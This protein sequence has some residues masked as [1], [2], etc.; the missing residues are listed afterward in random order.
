MNR[1]MWRL[2]ASCAV[3]CGALFA[4]HAWAAL[5]IEVVSSMPELVSN[6]DALI[7]VTGAS[8]APSVSY[9]GLDVSNRFTPDP[10]TPGRWLGLI[11]GFQD[12]KETIE[13]RF[14]GE[15]AA[16]N[17]VNH[18]VNKTLFAGPQQT[19]FLCELDALGLKPAPTANL[20]PTRNPDCAA[21]STVKYYYRNTAGMWQEWNVANR[22]TDVAMTTT[23]E[24]KTVPL[25]VRQERGV[26]NRAGYIINI[27][28]DPA[29]GPA[30]TFNSRGGSAWNGKLIYSFGPGARAGY[31]QG[32]NFGGLNGADMFITETQ[33]GTLDAYI[34]RGY[35]IASGSLNSFGTST[36]DVVSAETAYKV[37]ERFIE[38]F[39][40]PTF[41][42]GHGVSGGS[43]QQ[44]MISNAYPGILD[45]IMPYMLFADAMTF[46]Q[47]MF[48]CE[49]LAN[50][51]KQGDWSREQLEAVG[52][53]YWGYCV[54]NGARYPAQR[55]DNCDT[56][57]LE[58]VDKDPALK[59]RGVRCTYQDNM[60]HTFGVDPKTG[61]ARSPWDNVGIQYGL[62][63]LNDGVIT[64][65][66]FLDINSRIG[67]HDADGNI[68]AERQVGDPEALRIAYETG[69]VNLGTGGNKNVPYVDFRRY[70][71][72][73]PFNRGDAN[74]D[75]HNSVHSA[76]V[77]A[78][79]Q[80]YTGTNA[81]HVQIIT[82][83]GPGRT[84]TTTPGSPANVAALDALTQMDKW[85]T[86]I[87]AD[88]SSKSMAEKVA[89]NRPADFV[90]ACY[91]NAGAAVIQG[92][93]TKDGYKVE[94]V[95][96]WDKCNQIFP[97]QTDPRIAAGGPMTDDVFK[98]QLKPIDMA[99]YKTA[100]NADQL[101]QLKTVF[102]DGVC[103]YSKPG[104]GNTGKI[105]TW[106]MFTDA[107][108]Y[109]GL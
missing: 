15:K 54:S 106:A 7:A 66:Q 48:D 5:G 16:V 77:E 87:K 55:A 38:E 84:D 56:P 100:P 101:A 13:A 64:W 24:G 102:A 3:A 99:D 4:S 27:L 98:C 34:T 71:D 1:K 40:T 76:I 44:Q 85:L 61:Y 74:V 91:T 25:I 95:T 45:G 8:G 51:F 12:G 90:N 94:K 69:R 17:I 11:V 107:G 50:V 53:L 70:L 68:V 72:G 108:E 103:D 43:M 73:D 93:P 105:V 88:T 18:A 23:S 58:M 89:A 52:G 79:L 22:P 46:S 19:P 6:G 35:A 92:D 63:A 42:I 67:G 33:T 26:I 83:L 37:K 30:P 14:G 80:K 75:V 2:T 20:I 49:L 96:D 47:P 32:R 62:K 31:H 65:A 28:H 86:A 104:V 21:P 59:A 10:T 78:R 36:D 41:T 9:R 82:A 39:G 60:I 29:A 109:A 97:K 81:N 57:V